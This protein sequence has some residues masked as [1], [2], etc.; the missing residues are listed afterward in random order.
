MLWQICLIVIYPVILPSLYTGLAFVVIAHYHAE[1]R[2]VSDF[3]LPVLTK[4]LVRFPGGGCWLLVDGCL[5]SGL[6]VWQ[7]KPI[8]Q[9]LYYQQLQLQTCIPVGCDIHKLTPSKE[10]GA[11]HSCRRRRRLVQPQAVKTQRIYLQMV[12]RHVIGRHI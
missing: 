4:Q 12:W 1:S 5:Q 7:T 11:W 8:M 6:V 9:S 10:I 3:S 2:A